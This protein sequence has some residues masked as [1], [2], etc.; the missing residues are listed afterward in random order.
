MELGRQG[1]TDFRGRTNSIA[2]AHNAAIAE[3]E[4]QAREAQRSAERCAFLS[5]TV[6]APTCSIDCA[7]ARSSMLRNALTYC[8]VAATGASA[9]HYVTMLSIASSVCPCHPAPR[10]SPYLALNG[11]WFNVC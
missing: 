11:L 7:A 2:R 9:L 1:V 6:L 4:R 3:E 10:P 8:C 5:M